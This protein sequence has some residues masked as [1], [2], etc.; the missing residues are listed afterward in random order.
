MHK[1]VKAVTKMKLFTF[2]EKKKI[3]GSYSSKKSSM[4]L[5]NTEISIR[6]LLI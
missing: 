3:L 4:N 1:K 6:K 2:A 5:H